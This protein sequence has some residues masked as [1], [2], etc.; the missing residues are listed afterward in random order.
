MKR[1]LVTLEVA[2]FGCGNRQRGKE[3]F[4]LHSSPGLHHYYVIEHEEWFIYHIS[5]YS[6]IVLTPSI[7]AGPTQL[8]I[9]D[10]TMRVQLTNRIVQG[11]S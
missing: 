11:Y 2:R 10:P 7:D 1:I 5:N 9:A 3:E 8:P 4:R 6:R